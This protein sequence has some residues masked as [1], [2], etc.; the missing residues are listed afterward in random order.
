MERVC[1][2]S[3]AFRCAQICIRKQP[4]PVDYMTHILRDVCTAVA[5]DDHIVNASTSI[6]GHGAQGEALLCQLFLRGFL[7]QR[8]KLVQCNLVCFA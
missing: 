5:N 2:A 8:W 1:V 4:A 6:I 3:Q 7:V